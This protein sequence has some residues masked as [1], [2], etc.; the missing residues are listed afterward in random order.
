MKWHAECTKSAQCAPLKHH[1]DECVERVTDQHEN[2]DHKGPKENCVEECEWIRLLS[3]LSVHY[4][5]ALPCQMGLPVFGF[6]LVAIS[7]MGTLKLTGVALSLVFHLS[8]CATQCAAPK[9]FRVLK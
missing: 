5:E 2:P 6:A 9:L 1:Y 4:G 8:H 3:D 7:M